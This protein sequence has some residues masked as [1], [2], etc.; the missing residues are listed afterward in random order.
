MR[1]CVPEA[2]SEGRDKWLHPTDT[3][4]CNCLSLPLKPASGTTLLICV[5]QIIP[6]FRPQA[7]IIRDTQ[8][9]TIWKAFGKSSKTPF[10]PHLHVNSFSSGVKKSPDCTLDMQHRALAINKW[11]VEV[12]TWITWLTSTHPYNIHTLFCSALKCLN[13]LSWNLTMDLPKTTNFLLDLE[14]KSRYKVQEKRHPIHGG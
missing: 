5:T 2:G 1:I 4:G 7:Q 12:A 13:V 14:L 11:K 6:R 10:G 3:V 9:R 8:R